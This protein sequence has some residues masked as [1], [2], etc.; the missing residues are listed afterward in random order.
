MPKIYFITGN[1]HKV[2]EISKILSKEGVDVELAAKD[3]KIPE[4][5]FD[6]IEEVAI[7]KAKSAFAVLKKPLI[8]EDTG[9][10]FDSYRNFPGIYAKRMYISLGF[11]GLLK[12]LHG[13]KRT[14]HFNVAICFIWGKNKFKVFSGELKGKFA[15]KVFEKNADRLPYEKIFI[16]RGKKKV[17]AKISLAEKNEFSH[18]A[19]AARKLAKWLNEN[20]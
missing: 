13:K 18:R 10:F 19:V 20:F 4:R 12:L 15:S 9:V 6:S 1:S 8:C 17:L 14:G 7:E 16:P 2:E 5:E 11:D 3:L